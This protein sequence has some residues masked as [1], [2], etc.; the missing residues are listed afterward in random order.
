MKNFDGFRCVDT[1]LLVNKQITQQSRRPMQP[2]NQIKKYKRD[3]TANTRRG[4]RLNFLGSTEDDQ[5]KGPHSATDAKKQPALD[6]Q[7]PLNRITKAKGAEEVATIEQK[8]IGNHV[9]C[10]SSDP[11][12]TKNRTRKRTNHLTRKSLLN[13]LEIERF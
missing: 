2:Q 9:T 1:L 3:W 10:A 12:Y 4:R 6:R 5:R 13:G 11:V 7:S 8:K